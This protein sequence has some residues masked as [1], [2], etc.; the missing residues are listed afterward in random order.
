MREAVDK[1]EHDR[2]ALLFLEL[3]EAAPQR[4]LLE[5]HLDRADDVEF[6]RNIT[7]RRIIAQHLAAELSDGV[8]RAEADD[9]GQPRS[10]GAAFGCKARGVLPHLHEGIL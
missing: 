8:E 6:L 9:P 7:E 2:A 3:V 1:S 10:G 4:V 5:L